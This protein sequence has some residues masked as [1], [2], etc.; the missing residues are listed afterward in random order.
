MLTLRI[1]LILCACFALSVSGLDPLPGEKPPTKPKIKEIRPGV[2]QVGGVL[3]EKTKKQISFPVIINMHEGLIEYLLV[4]GKGKTHESLLV[5]RT[6]PFDIHVAMLLLGVKGAA[7]KKIPEDPR[8]PVPGE[9][10]ALQL[11]WANKGKP[12]SAPIEKFVQDRHH[13]KPMAPGPFV[14]NGSIVFDGMFIAHRDGNLFS[15][16]TDPAALANNPRMGRHDDE[17]WEPIKK[18]LPPLDSN[19]TLTVKLVPS[20]K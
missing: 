5:T 19:A 12:M 17:N 16:I 9:T 15:L 13:K 2:F 10:I 14:Y 18:D 11:K 3:L 1:G 7:G 20:Q 8:K 6:E 4:S